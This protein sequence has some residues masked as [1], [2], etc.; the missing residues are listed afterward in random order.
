LNFVGKSVLQSDEQM[1]RM[2]SRAQ[3][4]EKPI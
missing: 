2:S 3:G 1:Q 4:K